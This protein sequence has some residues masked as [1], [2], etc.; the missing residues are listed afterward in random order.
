[1][2]FSLFIIPLTMIFTQLIKSSP[3]KNEWL[4]HVAVITGGILGS[5]YALY[6][7]GDLLD[8]IVQGIVY[9]ASASGIYDLAKNTKEAI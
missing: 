4:P 7:G 3:L 6:Y 8:L 9:G 5:I 2:E 1:M